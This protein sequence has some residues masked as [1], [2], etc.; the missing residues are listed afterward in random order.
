MLPWMFRRT[1]LSIDV[2]AISGLGLHS[3]RALGN[4]GGRS[5][6]GWPGLPVASARLPTRTSAST[7][8]SSTFRGASARIRRW[9]RARPSRPCGCSR[10]FGSWKDPCDGRK[11][12]GQVFGDLP[13]EFDRPATDA[14][15][16]HHEALARRHLVDEP[17]AQGRRI[18]AG[19]TICQ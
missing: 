6:A 14:D 13:A 16:A 10:A 12:H 7:E 5:S 19:R 8:D 9:H 15:V 2:L 17:Q 18:P 3:A 11:R 1:G 4:R